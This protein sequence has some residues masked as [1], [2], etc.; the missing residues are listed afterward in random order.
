MDIP[1]VDKSLTKLGVPRR[2]R[3]QIGRVSK[4]P[5]VQAAALV[6]LLAAG[7]MAARKFAQKGS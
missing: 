2:M 6:S 3:K 5:T 1:N 4:S 7:L